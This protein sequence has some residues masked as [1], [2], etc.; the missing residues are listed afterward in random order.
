MTLH[1]IHTICEIC[2]HKNNIKSYENYICSGCGQGY[3]YDNDCYRIDL[4]EEQLGLLR[5][6]GINKLRTF[7]K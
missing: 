6:D 2:G 3:L 4:T 1:D 5:E 7:V